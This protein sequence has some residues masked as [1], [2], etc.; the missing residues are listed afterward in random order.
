MY[1][2]SIDVEDWPMD[3]A[4]SDVKITA[5]RTG[6]DPPQKCTLLLFNDIVVILKRD[7]KL[8]RRGA[9]C[10]GLDKVSKLVDAYKASTL[11]ISSPMKKKQPVKQE[12]AFRGYVPLDLLSAADLGSEGTLS[13]PADETC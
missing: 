7:T 12:L 2:D 8:F 6:S 1:I 5:R 13:L 3:Q 9:D 10:I 4:T 11:A